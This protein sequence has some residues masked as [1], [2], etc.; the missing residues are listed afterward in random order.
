MEL[1]T[2]VLRGDGVSSS[3]E[4]QQIATVFA[5]I[6]LVVWRSH[7]H[8][9]K[10]GRVPCRVIDIGRQTDAVPHRDHDIAIHTKSEG[11]A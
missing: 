5:E 9:R 8:G 10:G 3:Q 4:K 11:R 1:A 6:I 7:Q 2:H